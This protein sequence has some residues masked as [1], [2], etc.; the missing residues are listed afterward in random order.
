MKDNYNILILNNLR[1]I[2]AI[3]V[4]LF[5]FIYTTVNFIKNDYVLSAFYFGRYGVQL[6][7]VISGIVIPLSL[8]KSNYSFFNF[9][10]FFL[11]RIVRIEPT[12]LVV[13]FLIILITMA[14]GNYSKINITEIVLHLGYLIPFFPKYYWINEAFWTLAIEFQFYVII[15]FSILLFQKS[16]LINRIIFYLIYII[17]PFIYPATNFFPYSSPIFLVGIC[18]CL[19]FLNKIKPLEFVLVLLSALVVIFIKIDPICAGISLFTIVIIHFFQNYSNSI[20]NF[21]G[22]ISY[23]FYLLHPVIGISCVNILSHRFIIWWQKPLVIIFGFC[24]TTV[25]S[26]FL[27]KFI[28]KPT[29]LLSKKIKL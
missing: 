13:I 26:Y 29:Q 15:S 6:F 16:L 11:K 21:F 19:L 28:E 17:M 2:A 9:K 27:Y 1:G 24:V 12:Y 14:K 22:K 23:S 7:F 3:S 10:N 18:W 8:F 5:H 20:L 25:F 4:C